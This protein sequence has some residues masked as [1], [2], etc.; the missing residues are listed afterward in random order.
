MNLNEKIETL[1]E[2]LNSILLNDQ[3]F[4]KK[5]TL[6]LSAELDKLIEMYYLCGDNTNYSSY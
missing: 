4:Y 3:S 1:R 6:E 5:E 2:Q